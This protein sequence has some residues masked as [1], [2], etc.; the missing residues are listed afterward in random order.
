VV[1]TPVKVEEL[2]NKR[3]RDNRK[4]STGETSF[5]REFFIKKGGKDGL[6]AQPK[7]CYSYGIRKLV[8]RLTTCVEK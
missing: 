4:T 8:D 1:I 3:I 5:K 7:T 2:I 6:R